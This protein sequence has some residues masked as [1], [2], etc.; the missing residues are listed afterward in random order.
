MHPPDSKRR[1]D[2][3]FVAYSCCED[4]LFYTFEFLLLFL[5][6]ISKFLQISF[7]GVNV[8]HQEIF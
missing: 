6:L 5:H 2:L 8:I 7:K 1:L 3:V 4:R